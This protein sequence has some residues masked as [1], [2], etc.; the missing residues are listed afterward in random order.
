MNGQTCIERAY[1]LVRTREFR[2][3]TQ[4]KQQLRRE[5]FADV[6]TCLHG[7]AIRR[8]LMRI[9]EEK[10]GRRPRANRSA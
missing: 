1:A 3:M 2:T 6:E 7:L 5:R 10:G 9:C 8:A 4:I